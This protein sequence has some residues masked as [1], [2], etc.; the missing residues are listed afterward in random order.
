METDYSHYPKENKRLERS[1][2]SFFLYDWIGI[3]YQGGNPGTL[4]R[5]S[6]RSDNVNGGE[7]P[8]QSRSLRP[9]RPQ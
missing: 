5:G 7:P 3:S 4:D 8:A 1:Y 6:I 9:R 2:N